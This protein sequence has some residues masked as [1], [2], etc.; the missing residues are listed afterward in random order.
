MS[1]RPTTRLLAVPIEVLVAFIRFL[2]ISKR[3]FGMGLHLSNTLE[4]TDA[5]DKGLAGS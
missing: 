3:A 2:E 1:S 4:A 5:I